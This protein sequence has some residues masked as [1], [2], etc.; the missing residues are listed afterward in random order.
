MGCQ[1]KTVDLQM[2]RWFPVYWLNTVS[3]NNDVVVEL[4]EEQHARVEAAFVE[5]SNVQTMLSDI[6]H[7]R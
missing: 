7:G 4:T 3:E 2:D 6:Y 5:F 1:M